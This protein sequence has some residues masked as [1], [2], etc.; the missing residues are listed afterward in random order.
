MGREKQET[1]YCATEGHEEK[2]A[3][4]SVDGSPACQA[5]YR[6]AKR[7]EA[8]GGAPKQ[9]PGPRPDPTKPFSR[10][11]GELSHH[12]RPTEDKPDAELL[13]TID[14]FRARYEDPIAVMK[15]MVAYLE[16]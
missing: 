10:H 2:V 14:W 13:A 12:K 6:R 7:E 11:G 3:G 9:Q 15:S 1:R 16:K 5:C 8:R 4:Y